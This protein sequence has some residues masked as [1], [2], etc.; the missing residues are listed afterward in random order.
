MSELGSEDIRLPHEV[1]TGD[2][3]PDDLKW[4]L[5]AFK[6]KKND[7]TVVLFAWH[8]QRMKH[9]EDTIQNGIY[10]LKAALDTRVE[11]MENA[12]ESVD[13]LISTLQQL[14][15]VLAEKPLTISQQIT[16]ELNTPIADSVQSCTTLAA[17]LKALL[18]QT[19][20][21]LK[22]AVRQQVTAS[23][24]TGLLLGGLAVIWI[25]HLLSTAH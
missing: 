11:K 20:T 9:G 19:Q 2:N 7:P 13:S 3:L 14:A 10:T 1:F 6:L 17:Q 16:H 15:S 25:K 5:S 21:T 4:L 22:L 23:F 8:W 12:A 24:T 18:H